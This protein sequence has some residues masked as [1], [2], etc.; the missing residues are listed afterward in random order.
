GV[1]WVAPDVVARLLSVPPFGPPAP[2]GVWSMPF[3]RS[4]WFSAGDFG[5][6]LF[7]L[8]SGFVIPFSFANRSRLGF[9]L[10]RVCRLWPTYA[11]GVSITIM[12]LWAVSNVFG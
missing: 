7:F 10:S 11:V 6:S 2:L 5:V 4:R 12:A 8:I 1:F 3:E 9:V